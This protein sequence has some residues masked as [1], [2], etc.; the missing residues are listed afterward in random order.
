MDRI[1]ANGCIGL[2]LSFD[3]TYKY[4]FLSDA[5]KGRRTRRRKTNSTI[6]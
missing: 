1:Q 4:G 5:I 6:S 3:N 2:L